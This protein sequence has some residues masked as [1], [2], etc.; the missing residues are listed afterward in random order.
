MGEHSATGSS[1]KAKPWRK[2]VAAFSASLLLLFVIIALNSTQF[3]IK[4]ANSYLSAYHT[5]ITRLE[6]QLD[7]WNKW[8]FPQISLTVYDTEIALN[9]IE[10][11]IAEKTFS[12]LATGF[13]P[14]KLQAIRIGKVA[15]TLGATFIQ[16]ENKAPD[17]QGPTFGL[18]LDAIP[19]IAIG[20]VTLGI[21]PDVIINRQLPV[22]K[23]SHL[24]LNSQRE[25]SSELFIGAK[26][27]FSIDATLGEKVWQANTQVHLSELQQALSLIGSLKLNDKPLVPQLT[28]IK[29]WPQVTG[30]M[31]SHIE[32]DLQSAKLSSQHIW[33]TPEIKFNKFGPLVIA[34]KY[35]STT[36]QTQVKTKDNTDKVA[37]DI[38]G[39]LNNLSLKVAPTA[40]D[41]NVTLAQLRKLYHY[42]QNPKAKPAH[43]VSVPLSTS[44]SSAHNQ[45][46]EPQTDKSVQLKF[47]LGLN[48][49]I[50]YKFQSQR[51]EFDT[52]SL[53]S[54]L[55]APK[56]VAPP[57]SPNINQEQTATLNH[58][59]HSA[60][61]HSAHSIQ[62]QLTPAQQ[63][64]Y[65][66]LSQ[67]QLT[68]SQ[69]QIAL[70]NK[71]LGSPLTINSHFE[72]KTDNQ[73]IDKLLEQLNAI[74]SSKKEPE[75]T[76]K[77][78]LTI[79]HIKG[80][81]SGKANISLGQQS[82]I[83][84]SLNKGAQLALA[85]VQSQAFDQL[86]LNNLKLQ[87]ESSTQLVHF[88][89]QQADTSQVQLSL[90]KLSL[91]LDG[92]EVTKSEDESQAITTKPLDLEQK[93]AAALD[94]EAAS[95][96]LSLSAETITARIQHNLNWQFH[97]TDQVP[98]TANALAS[99]VN[100]DWSNQV[101]W[102][103]SGLSIERFTPQRRFTP[104][105]RLLQIDELSLS[106]GLKWQKQNLMFKDTWL[107]DELAFTSQETLSFSGL[108]K[109]I[110]QRVNSPTAVDNAYMS[111]VGFH[112]SGKASIYQAASTIIE[113]L[114]TS[115]PPIADLLTD[116]EIQADTSLSTH[117]Q[118]KSQP[119]GLTIN[120]QITSELSNGEGSVK[121][122]S[123]KDLMVTSA[124]H[125]Q[126]L[127]LSSDQDSRSDENPPKLICQ[128]MKFNASEVNP[129]VKLTN[130]SIDASLSKALTQDTQ[131]ID[132]G[133]NSLRQ[134][135]ANVSLTAKAKLLDGELLI[136][137][138][139][140]NPEG[141]SQAYI[142][143]KAVALEELLKLQPQ[144]GIYADGV[145]D[146]VLPLELIAGQASIEG[147]RLTARA[148]G[149]LIKIGDNPAVMQMRQSQPHL[150]FA[151]SALEHLNYNE[152]TSSFNMKPSGDALL[153]V[154]IKG[155]SQNVERPIHFN[156]S[157]EENM[158]Q[159]FKSLRIGNTLQQEIEES[160]Q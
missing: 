147:G 160:V 115:A 26:P 45:H 83:E 74:T 99:L 119:Q 84:L 65:Q 14:D 124:C 34:P 20:E 134:L 123:F 5:Q 32:L 104:Y 73:Q 112:L 49:G 37:F 159:L 38:S 46:S 129:G 2:I 6:W 60:H 91:S 97:Y 92:L 117:Y 90:P 35:L 79:A 50:M 136:P 15:I 130:V 76:I 141:K 42:V 107:L 140:L 95:A 64:D 120:A 11:D 156:Y 98:F 153:N 148:P 135:P 138:F 80:E 51:L 82:R 59:A 68:L 70:A 106:Q 66:R 16:D 56:P 158:I 108:E 52:L 18:S 109:E 24:N 113:T 157:H 63:H 21:K 133:N 1:P 54:Q 121:G 13:S 12:E 144:V 110:A 122:I 103:V 132:Q 126:E 31:Q 27:L 151:F 28:D 150:D 39:H 116:V 127:A 25:L 29:A 101:N 22:I 143:L 36:K 72:L 57:V 3:I 139:K 87:T 155:K 146:A 75:P 137:E 77:L 78:P 41:L 17:T 152:L 85:S 111:G 149:G 71:A 62:A 10:I 154:S 30:D 88:N 7:A 23:L 114:S 44:Q 43:Q 131:E 86:S 48:N 128:K 93:N 4:A 67:T 61:T 102:Q 142:M 58:S 100:S 118:I 125:L 8:R 40:L 47:M 33:Q 94:Q 145:F 9:Q 55:L 69:G 53:T 105:Q 81:A 19:K 89:N 96:S